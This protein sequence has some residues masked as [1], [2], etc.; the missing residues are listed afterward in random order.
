MAR[1]ALDPDSDPHAPVTRAEYSELRTAF[2][3]FSEHTGAALKEIADKLRGIEG[4]RQVT[5]PSVLAIIG[6]AG[7]AFGFAIKNFSDVASLAHK[8]DDTAESVSDFRE[9]LRSVETGTKAIAIEQE[10]QNK[11]MADAVNTQ[12]E[13]QDLL[14]A[15]FAQGVKFDLP[16]RGY[17]PLLRIGDAPSPTN[18]N[19]YKK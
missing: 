7:A 3:S 4:A 18:G 12:I 5:L 8:A 14:N 10:T 13:R 16:E 15:L 19:G 11:W 17:F 6:L 2:A 9:R 1:T